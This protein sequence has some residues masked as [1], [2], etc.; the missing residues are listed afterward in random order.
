MRAK[1]KDI[2][3]E[4]NL[5]VSTISRVVNG[6]DRVDPQ[7]RRTVLKALENYGYKPNEIARSLRLRTAKTIVIVVPDIANNY[8]A[9]IIK[10][11]QAVCRKNGYSVMVCNS[12]ENRVQE[13]EILSAFPNQQIA[14]M[15]LASVDSSANLVQHFQKEGMPVVYV[16]NMPPATQSYDSVA[17]NNVAT[18]YTLTQKV[19]ER[20]YSKIG[21]IT[22]DLEQSSGSERLAG[23]KQALQDAAVA[24]DEKRVAI[25]DFKMQSGYR[26]MSQ[27][28]EKGGKL[29]AVIV[30]NN[31]MAYG[32]IKKIREA[33]LAIPED[34]AIAAFDL[35]DETE[36]IYPKVTSI[37]QPATEIGECAA[38]ILLMRITT[39][40]DGTYNK[41]FLDTIFLPGESW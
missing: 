41:R 25:G 14:G 30:S 10:G 12:D 36:L 7:T 39:Q 29:D 8:Y 19:I 31:F 40:P 23:Y 28:L 9:S 3:K 22:G 21:F 35:V 33:G 15:I 17:I 6:K 5:S 24:Y 27:L 34:I 4:L 11:A 2:A 16:D 18:A 37:N 20:G 32:A 26:G 13:R 1:L 38:D